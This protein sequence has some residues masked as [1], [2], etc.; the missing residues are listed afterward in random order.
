MA[1]TEFFRFIATHS[2]HASFS[3]SLVPWWTPGSWTF[4][5][6]VDWKHARAF[7]RSIRA[8]PGQ[9]TTIV[10]LASDHWAGHWKWHPNATCARNYVGS[11]FST[12]VILASDHWA[13]HWKWHPNA[14]CARNY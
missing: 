8:L 2:L 4:R 13:G 6:H 3:R 9:V 14:T 5:S 11:R 1:D 12:I 7:L 10:I